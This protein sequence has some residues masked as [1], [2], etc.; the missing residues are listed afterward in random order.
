M[1][2]LSI[3]F[4]LAGSLSASELPTPAYPLW[5]GHESVADYAKRVN[6][7]PTKTLD[8]GNNIKLELVLIPAGKF[9][10]GT[11]AP[12][13]PIVGQTML[14]VSGGILFL[15]LLLLLFRAWRKGHRPQFS[16]ALMLVMMIVTSVGVWGGV[17]WHEAL[18][19]VDREDEHPAHDVIL[20]QPFYMGKFD[21]TQEQYQHVMGTNHSHFK[22]KSNPVEAVSWDDA[23]D[24]C[25]KLIVQTKQSIR[26]PTEA[27]WEFSC[28]AGTRTTYHSG[29]T[30]ADLDRVAWYGANSKGTTHPVGQKEPNTFDLYDMHGNVWQWCQ[31]WYGKNYYSKS[32][33]ESPRGPAHGGW[34]VFRGGSWDFNAEGSRV[35]RGG[36]WGFNAEG[37]RSASRDNCAPVLWYPVGGF[38]VVV[39]VPSFGP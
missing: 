35:L 30:E 38:R 32:L 9:I 4:V 23:Q 8:L 33:T 21:I 19:V 28:R 1:R 25:K 34:L 13:K 17:R 3:V 2:I 15:A 22:G 20:T 16:L 27:E 24:F 6:L 26:L 7:S 39:A 29:N 36:S 31:D 37:C 5:D 11:P 14:G 10:M 18:K 12:E